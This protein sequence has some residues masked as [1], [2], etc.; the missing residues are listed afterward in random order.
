MPPGDA[1]PCQCSYTSTRSSAPSTV[2]PTSIHSGGKVARSTGLGVTATTSGLRARTLTGQGSHAT[3]AK[4]VGGRSTTSRRRCW[5]RI[6]S[7]CRPGFSPPS[8]YVCRVRL[9]ISPERWVSTRKPYLRVFRG[10][11]KLNLP[12]YV[13]FC[14]FLR[15]VRQR[16]AFEQVELILQAALDPAIASR[17]RTSVKY[18]CYLSSCL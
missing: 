16:T 18:S 5:P 12:E 14:Q 2:M 3:A 17:A 10:I 11:S 8:C 9:G 13:R 1:Q 6:S 7:H 4:P 15:N